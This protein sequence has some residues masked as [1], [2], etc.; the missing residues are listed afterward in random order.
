MAIDFRSRWETFSPNTKRAIMLASAFGVI[1][2]VSFLTTLLEKD[3]PKLDRLDT[4][5]DVEMML[6]ERRDATLD[7]LN[8]SQ[9]A[10]ARRITRME[11]NLKSSQKAMQDALRELQ[12]QLAQEREPR[13]LG[14]CKPS[15]TI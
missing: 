2:F 4:A 15:S 13:R 1:L 9:I 5:V 14:K 8:A 6:P 10:A 12:A 7:E 11:Q 3:E